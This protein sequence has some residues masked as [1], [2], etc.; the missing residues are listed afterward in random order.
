MPKKY[1]TDKQLEELL[2]KSDSEQDEQNVSMKNRVIFI[3]R[4]QVFCIIWLGILFF[5]LLLVICLQDDW[6]DGDSK[7]PEPAEEIDEI[8]D[9]FS[10][11]TP[12]DNNSDSDDSS[13]TDQQVAD[14]P[15]PNKSS[16]VWEAKTFSPKIHEFD[17]SNCGC[18]IEGDLDNTAL[19]YFEFFFHTGIN[20]TNSKRHK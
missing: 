3:I 13:Q 5:S 18:K 14:I 7:T 12:V 17:T 15:G 16:F 1:L 20:G 6:S 8:V 19:K 9:F 11:R 2:A 10:E 4:C